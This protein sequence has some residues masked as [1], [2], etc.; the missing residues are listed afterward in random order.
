MKGVRLLVGVLLVLVMLETAVSAVVIPRQNDVPLKP[1]EMLTEKD[2]K[3]I[4]EKYNVTEN[5]IS[6]LR[7]NYHM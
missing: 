7:A 5:D 1:P 6:L 2:L 4:Y 3:V